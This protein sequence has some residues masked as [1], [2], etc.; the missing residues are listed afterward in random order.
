[1]RAPSIRCGRPS[2][3]PVGRGFT[4]ME[5]LLAMSILAIMVTLLMGAFRVG[6]RAW[7]KGDE[8]VAGMQRLRAVLNLVR[9]Q[10]A[11]TVVPA[12]ATSGGGEARV[13]FQGTGTALRFVS[14][15]SLVPGAASG[16]VLVN[17]RA[18]IGPD[19][20]WR[21]RFHEQPLLGTDSGLSSEPAAEA[22]RE[23]IGGLAAVRF[24]Y[25]ATDPDTG[26]PAWLERWRAEA[27]GPLP[28]LVRFWLQPDLQ[29]LPMAIAARLLPPAGE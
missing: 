10:L 1:M 17:Y 20:R 14:A 5:L 23:L 12:P 9:L 29:R 28:A 4:L 24:E 27:D 2:C 8:V 6:Y 19:G 25:L 7:E 3:R 13:D 22:Y 16:Q 11:A 21:L 18:D 26:E 15:R